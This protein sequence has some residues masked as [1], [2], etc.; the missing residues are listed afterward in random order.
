MIITGIAHPPVR[1]HERSNLPSTELVYLAM[2]AL[3]EYGAT[4]LLTS[5]AWGWEQALASA[6]IE[7]EIPFTVA[8]PYPGREVEWQREPR[9][10]YYDLLARASEV[11]RVNDCYSDTSIMEGHQWRVQR[12]GLVLALWDYEFAGDTFSTIKYALQA[13][14]KVVNLW[15]DWE[16]LTNLRR[17][18]FSFSLQRSRTGAQVF[19]R[20]SSLT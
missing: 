11:Y 7:M 17:P 12:A 6:A 1:L 5:L 18:V 4:Q 9:I 2:R 10:R 20:K 13:G 8:I 15:Q 19:N 16:A 3:R 14:K